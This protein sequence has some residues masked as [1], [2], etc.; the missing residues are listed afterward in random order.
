LM[1]E[2]DWWPF[3]YVD[4]RG[5]LAGI[6]VEMGMEIAR[7]LG[8]QP[9]FIR[10]GVFN[11]LARHLEEDA[12]D[13]IISYYSY[14]PSRSAH[15]FITQPYLMDSD[16][17]LVSHT[18]MEFMRNQKVDLNQEEITKYLNQRRLLR[19]GTLADTSYEAWA[20]E[21][22][23][24]AR[25]SKA[26]P[27]EVPNLLTDKEV[28]VFYCAHY[29]LRFFLALHP[30]ILLNYQYVQMDRKDLIS[31]AVA[32]ENLSLYFWLDSYIASSSS[33][34]RKLEELIER[35][36]A[37]EQEEPSPTIVDKALSDPWRSILLA[38]LVSVAAIVVYVSQRRIRRKPNSK[39]PPHWLLNMWTVLFSLLLGTYAGLAFPE[40]TEL[41][42]PFGDIF[43]NYLL[44]AGIP[45]LFCVV[46]LN[47]TRLMSN[48]GGLRFFL[49]F[50][51]ILLIFVSIGAFL[52]LGIGLV[53]QP[54]SGLP[55]E[56]QQRLAETL[57]RQSAESSLA[58]DTSPGAMLWMIPSTMIPNS[59]LK[60]F[61]ENRTLSILFFGILIAFILLYQEEKRK[62]KVISVLT[63]VNDLFFTLFKLSYYVLPFGLFCLMMS[64]ASAFT[65]NS[66]LFMAFIKLLVCQGIMLAA[67]FFIAVGV[68]LWKVPM[69]LPRYLSAI[70]KP[71][72]IIFS[73]LSTLA[74]LPAIME[75]CE[76]EEAFQDENV[77]GT[78]P[79]LLIMVIPTIASIFSLTIVFLVQL[80]RIEIGWVG[81]L[82][83]GINSV[84]AGIAASGI[85]AP[86]D[87][88]SVSIVTAPLGIPV[89]QALF[90]L[91]PYTL[92]GAR[93][94]SAFCIILNFAIA[95]FFKKE[96]KPNLAVKHAVPGETS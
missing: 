78:L 25:L 80:L 42:S 56:S 82:F 22:F 44:L 54:G 4:E 7:A 53:I 49:K 17:I 1:A 92:T 89:T 51:G 81:Y 21:T 79:L 84:I 5:E 75:V 38:V 18:L 68:S 73:L 16:G 15:L 27:E 70:K 94:D 11:D 65:D 96:T 31:M 41:L 86:A 58:I 95:R 87:L 69:P 14:T 47:F 36:D 23:P 2:E 88:Y 67:W 45:I 8:V 43:F 64:Q 30:E 34:N 24:R 3:F 74:T 57:Q 55:L 59:I 62:E 60:A 9:V 32:Q 52:G 19:I 50:M 35:Y 61:V 85:P 13:V 39:K 72:M 26:K 90:F 63:V 28:D 83:I 10:K 77:K 40:V 76:R 71:M 33:R 93:V 20:V 12:A 91:L 66:G 6:D 46:I 37:G 29:W 48:I